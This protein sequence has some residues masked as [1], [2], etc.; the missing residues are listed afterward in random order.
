MEKIQALQ[1]MRRCE[2]FGFVNL[3]EVYQIELTNS[4]NLSC[5]F[6]ARKTMKR[7]V[8]YLKLDLIRRMI[9]NRD[10]DNSYYVEL[11]MAGEPL[12]HPELGKVV[13]MLKDINLV[14][15][16]STNGILIDKKIDELA[17][18]D[19]ITVSV[20]SVDKETYERLRKGAKYERLH[21]NI[22]LLLETYSYLRVDLQ[23]IE[24]TGRDVRA[25]TSKLHEMYSEYSNVV[26]RTVK[27]CSISQR[28]GLKA[29]KDTLC[30][31]PWSSVSI[32]HDGDVVPCCYDFD[33]SYVYGNLYE[34]TLKDIWH[35]DRTKKFRD[36][37][38][39]RCYIGI[40]KYC[41]IKSPVFL[42]MSM[43]MNRLRW[44]KW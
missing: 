19:Y 16:L 43:L 13:A 2:D 42:H 9:K 17:K 18:V 11:Q 1:F 31:N 37:H 44:A 4:C 30:L 39:K 21:E 26:V 20:D 12:L 7:P 32:H 41:Y 35:S 25:E 38:T 14:V 5:D 28:E 23:I 33:K 34:D 15:G 6:C 8:G 24:F 27:D 22:K 10:F 3:P 29:E 36:S 40:C